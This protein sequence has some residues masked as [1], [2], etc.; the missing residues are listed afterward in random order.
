MPLPAV[1]HCNLR[2]SHSSKYDF[3]ASC[4]SCQSLVCIQLIWLQV[5]LSKSKNLLV[6]L[7]LLI[8]ISEESDAPRFLDLYILHY[9][10]ES[11][12]HNNETRMHAITST[13][14]VLQYCSELNLSAK[15]YSIS[16]KQ[17]CNSF[18]KV[19]HI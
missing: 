19:A 5:P 17:L 1:L 8:A 11:L 15:K 7:L 2:R 13:F 16:E 12:R 6:L 4:I 14:P 10:S 18:H 3:G 9:S